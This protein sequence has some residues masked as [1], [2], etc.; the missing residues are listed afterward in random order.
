[1]RGGVNVDITGFDYSLLPTGRMIIREQ[2]IHGQVR[3]ILKIHDVSCCGG[4]ERG[5]LANESTREFAAQFM[6]AFAAWVE[7][8]TSGG[9]E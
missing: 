1:M 2:H 8:K 4:D 3:G 7:T 9:R 5:D 6:Q